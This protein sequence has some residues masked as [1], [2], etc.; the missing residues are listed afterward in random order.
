MVLFPFVRTEKLA[1]FFVPDNGANP[2]PMVAVAIRADDLA[3]IGFGFVETFF[4]PA[5]DDLCRWNIVL[6]MAA[7]ARGTVRVAGILPAIRGR[8]ALDTRISFFPL[9]LEPASNDRLRWDVV[10]RTV[11]ALTVRIDLFGRVHDLRRRRVVFVISMSVSRDSTG[12]IISN[13]SAAFLAMKDQ[14]S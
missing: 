8:D 12:W 7:G 9:A 1:A 13:A 2:H 5:G 10:S 11:A 14:S 4:L 6:L 3:G